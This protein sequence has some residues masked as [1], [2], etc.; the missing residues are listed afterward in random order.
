MSEK[1]PN[2]NEHLD[3][4][5][6]AESL[7][8]HERGYES[9]HTSVMHVSQAIQEKTGG[10]LSLTFKDGQV[11]PMIGEGKSPEE[12]ADLE[13]NL[14]ALWDNFPDE[15]KTFVDGRPAQEGGNQFSPDFKHAIPSLQSMLELQDGNNGLTYDKMAEHYLHGNDPNV[16][17]TRTKINANKVLVYGAR[18]NMPDSVES[19]NPGRTELTQGELLAQF[20]SD[21]EANARMAGLLENEQLPDQAA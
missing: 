12:V 9:A 13:K 16:N 20:A 5:N 8:L 19:F 14:D 7:S 18:T 3:E 6:H 2:T 21:I 17:L 15:V 1:V 10:V 4:T 11:R